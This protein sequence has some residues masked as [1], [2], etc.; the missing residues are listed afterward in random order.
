MA[1]GPDIR[2]PGNFQHQQQRNRSNQMATVTATATET[3]SLLWGRDHLGNPVEIPIIGITGEN[4]SGKTIFGCTIDPKRTAVFDFEKSAATYKSAGFL[5]VDMYDAMME[6]HP[7]GKFTDEQLWLAL[8]AEME[9][10]S[11]LK[12][13]SGESYRVAFVDPFSDV[14]SGIFDHICNN[15]ARFGMTKEQLARMKGI[16]WGKVNSEIKKLCLKCKFETFV[17][18]NHMGQKF[19]SSGAATNQRKVKGVNAFYEACHLY[20]QLERSPDPKTG[21]RSEKPSAVVLKD[22]LAWFDPV[23]F[24][25]KP[26]LPQRIPVCTPD[27]IRGYLQHPANWDKPKKGETVE[28]HEMTEDERMNYEIHRLELAKEAA[29]AETRKAE[30]QAKLLAIQQ[31]YG[32]GQGQVK[33]TPEPAAGQPVAVEGES[34][35]VATQAVV[36]DGS[37]APVSVPQPTAGAVEQ[38]PFTT[39]VATS[40]IAP[41]A[42]YPQL[43]EIKRLKEAIPIADPDRWLTVLR[44]YNVKSAV[45]LTPDQANDL[46]GKMGAKLKAQEQAPAEPPPVTEA[47][48]ALDAWANQKAAEEKAWETA[49]AKN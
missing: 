13:S 15:P 9:R 27:T 5:H 48:S 23:T 24:A 39:N 17:F 37:Q 14:Q 31:Q 4:W 20:L 36:P 16:A 2:G 38:P 18:A 12:N 30:S 40:P 10:V 29:D 47:R 26:F 35:V 22:R 44:N 19:D 28:L 42:T 45:H 34:T 11:K 8:S 43:M 32:L 6:R 49:T 46:I 3:E 21:K 41:T 33:G 25:P 1:V 7:D